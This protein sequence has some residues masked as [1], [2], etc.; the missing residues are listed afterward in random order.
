M[1]V[2]GACSLM[3]GGGSVFTLL[4]RITV[5]ETL[6]HLSA[7]GLG[8]WLLGLKHPSSGAS[9]PLCDA[10]SYEGNSG[11]LEA[12]TK[13]YYP[14]LL[15]PVSLSPR[16]ATAACASMG[17]PPILADRSGPVSYGVSA[18]S[19][20]GHGAHKTFVP[21]KMGISVS[22]GPLGVLWLN[23]TGIQSQF[24]WVLLLLLWATQLGSLMWNS[25]PLLLWDNFCIIIVF[26]LLLYYY[27]CI[28]IYY[29]IYNYG[30]PAWQAWISFYF[31]YT[32]PAIF[33]S[34]FFI[35]GCKVW[36]QGFY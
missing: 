15:L 26:Q 21:S 18:F 8:Y 29:N 16:W 34:F 17:D 13:E 6:N 9:R 2:A 28:L 12:H 31:H 36:I 22:L 3:Y 4:G 10:W 27:I 33:F 32:P 20:L 35:F 23:P 24:L 1:R 30:L 25:E 7:D 14:R 11:L 5:R 19:P